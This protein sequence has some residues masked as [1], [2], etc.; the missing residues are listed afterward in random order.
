MERIRAFWNRGWL[1]KAVLSIAGLLIICCVIGVLVPRRIQAPA[2]AAPTA[3]PQGAAPVA[4]QPTA[5]PEPTGAPDPTDAPEPTQAPEPT[6]APP[7]AAKV[8]DKVEANGIALTVMNVSKAEA[9]G[10][11]QKAEAGNTYVIVEVLIENISA[12]KAPY[13]PLYFKIKDSDGFEY[14]AT[15]NTGDRSLKSGDLAIGEKARGN[16]AVEVK[17]AAT[18]LVLEYKPIIFGRIDPIRVVLE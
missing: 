15:I 8:G 13:N 11:F 4:E 5:V 16:V 12:E 3:A 2:A 18:G 10:S 1:G 7:S 17:Q 6:A 14:N 9:I